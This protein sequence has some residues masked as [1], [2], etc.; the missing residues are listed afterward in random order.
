MANIVCL[1][2]PIASASSACEMRLMARS[3]LILLST[4]PTFIIVIKQ[5]SLEKNDINS[6]GYRG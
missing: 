6:C 3:T 4:F 2:T 5:H 1:L